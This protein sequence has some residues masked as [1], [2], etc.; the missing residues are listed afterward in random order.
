MRTIEEIRTHKEQIMNLYRR[1]LITDEQYDF[2]IADLEDELSL[3]EEA[4][5]EHKFDS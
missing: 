1:G 2:S 4:R 5:N 3:I